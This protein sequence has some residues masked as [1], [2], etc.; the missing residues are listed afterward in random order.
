MK[1][2]GTGEGIERGE[3]K[4]IEG[5]G[6]IKGEKREGGGEERAGKVNER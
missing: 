4:E 3:G 2:R 6:R 5:E 1:R